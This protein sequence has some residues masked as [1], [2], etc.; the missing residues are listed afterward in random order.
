MRTKG[1]YF[2]AQYYRLRSRRGSRKAICAIAASLLTTAYH[3][4]KNGACYQDLGA[5][6]SDQRAKTKHVQRMV[7]RRES[8]GY[9][10][11]IL[12]KAA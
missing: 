11:K 2:Q 4:L 12:P 5:N 3:M 6:H 8:L 7:N 9:D 10:V 1:S